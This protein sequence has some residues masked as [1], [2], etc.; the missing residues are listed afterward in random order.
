M[1]I[2]LKHDKAVLTTKKTFFGVKN[3]EGAIFGG[4]RSQWCGVRSRYVGFGAVD[5][6]FEGQFCK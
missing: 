2:F 6:G 3:V 5:V 4:V 1:Y